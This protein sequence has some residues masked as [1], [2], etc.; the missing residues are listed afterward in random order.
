M[1]GQK[2]SLQGLG[3]I[4][5]HLPLVSSDDLVYMVEKFIY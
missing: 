4:R 2:D 1:E 3:L 5:L